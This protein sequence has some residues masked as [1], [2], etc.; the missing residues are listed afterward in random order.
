MEGGFC[1][2]MVALVRVEG[3]KNGLTNSLQFS[4]FLC[5]SGTHSVCL[6]FLESSSVK[7]APQA[8]AGDTTDLSTGSD[9]GRVGPSGV[10][11]GES[12]SLSRLILQGGGRGPSPE[13]VERRGCRGY[14]WPSL[15]A[16]HSASPCGILAP[17]HPLNSY[18]MVFED[19]PVF[20][21]GT[22]APLDSGTR[23]SRYVHPTQN[24]TQYLVHRLW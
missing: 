8:W 21:S 12:V 1:A 23:F 15:T 14:Q 18:H 3:K 22:P 24:L 4:L 20:P 13:K 5:S 17:L 2:G 19:C 7:S 11:R 6:N 9:P 10:S 16:T